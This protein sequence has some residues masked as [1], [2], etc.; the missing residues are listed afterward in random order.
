MSYIL[1]L[2][3]VLSSLNPD[4][5][6]KR[7]YDDKIFYNF[8]SYE[9]ELYI[10]SNKGVFKVNPSAED[11]TIYDKSITG[12]INSIFQ[13]NNNFI[14]KFTRKISLAALLKLDLNILLQL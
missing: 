3:T 9:N 7:I 6:I 4:F 13:K 5:T 2:L 11:L 12:P 1:L 8:V 10:S 14:V